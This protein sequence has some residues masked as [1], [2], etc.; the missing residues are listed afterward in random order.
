MVR[1]SDSESGDKEP[2]K[3]NGS[4]SRWKASRIK[5]KSK[6]YGKGLWDVVEKGPTATQ[7][8]PASVTL[9]NESTTGSEEWYYARRDSIV[10]GPCSAEALIGVFNNIDLEE[11]GLTGESVYVFHQTKT[12]NAWEPWSNQVSNQIQVVW[13]QAQCWCSRHLSR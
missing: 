8:S 4:V 13:L 10:K 3:Y 9:G 2:K 12:A 1:G 11:R 6:L 7:A 5:L